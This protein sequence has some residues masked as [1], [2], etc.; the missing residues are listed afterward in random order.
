MQSGILNI[1]AAEK[2]TAAGIDVVM[3]RCFAVDA[4]KY[5]AHPRC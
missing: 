1:G 5:R 3:D 2:L 4:A